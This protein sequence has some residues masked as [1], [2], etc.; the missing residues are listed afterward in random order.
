MSIWQYRPVDHDKLDLGSGVFCQRRELYKARRRIAHGVDWWHVCAAQ[1][2]G[3]PVADWIPLQPEEPDGWQL[4]DLEPK[5]TL[6]PS[7]LCRA[8]RLH[9]H[10]TA[11]V[12]IA[13]G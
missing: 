2:G 13:A 4:V 8:C 6:T 5:I 11:G 1:A 3:R 12:W 7:V 10:I 9:G